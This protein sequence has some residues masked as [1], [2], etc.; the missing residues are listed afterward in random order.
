MELSFPQ[1]RSKLVPEEAADR[2]LAQEIMCDPAEHTLAQRAMAIGSSDQ[3][4]MCSVLK[5]RLVLRALV[6]Q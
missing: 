3:K 4:S 5:V 6:A 1:D 2:A